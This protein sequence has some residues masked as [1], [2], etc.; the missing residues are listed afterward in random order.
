M[1]L[2][3]AKGQEIKEVCIFLSFPSGV[4]Q[5]TGEVVFMK[6]NCLEKGCRYYHVIERKCKIDM[7]LEKVLTP[8]ALP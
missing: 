5:Q 7:A 3:N 6:V 4:N 1:S 2:L 8:G